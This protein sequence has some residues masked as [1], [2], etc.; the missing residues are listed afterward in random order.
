MS[1][2]HQIMDAQTCPKCGKQFYRVG[3]P[4]CDFPAS[5]PDMGKIRRQQFTAFALL[6]AL[7]IVLVRLFIQN[8]SF[9]LPI[10]VG[11]FGLVLLGWMLASDARGRAYA[12]AV[13]LLCAGL[14]PGFFYCTFSEVAHRSA[15]T[16][17]G[18]SFVPWWWNDT[19]TRWLTGF[20]GCLC[21]AWS[22]WCFYQVIRPRKRP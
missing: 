6:A 7:L 19:T 4:D 20:F 9:R 12:L 17:F 16:L 11:V 1:F 13:G 8:P 10:L 14:S 15:P 21:A 22:L 2:A 3:C 18:I 5:P